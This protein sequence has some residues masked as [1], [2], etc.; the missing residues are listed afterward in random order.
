M[1]AT[2]KQRDTASFNTATVYFLFFCMASM[3]SFLLLADRGSEWE[4]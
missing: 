4:K 2:L 1:K 3:M